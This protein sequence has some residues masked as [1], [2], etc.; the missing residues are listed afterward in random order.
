MALIV[1]TYS[2]GAT[3]LSSM[4]QTQNQLT[5]LTAEASSGQYADLGLQLGDQSGYELSLRN[6]T[7]Q[8]Q[9]LT[10]ANNLTVTNLKTAQSALDSIRTDAQTARHHA[11]LADRRLEQRRHDPAERPGPT[12]CSR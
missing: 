2:L 12:R 7:N 6:Q 1:S 4:A 8:L 10:T 3:V 5:Q 9:S 11:D